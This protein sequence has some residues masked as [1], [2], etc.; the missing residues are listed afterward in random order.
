MDQSVIKMFK[1]HYLPKTWHALSM[2]CDVSDELEKAA[3]VPE[4]TEVEFQKE[5]ALRH[6]RS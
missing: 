1:A 4:K 3:Q 6:W 2:K 5:M